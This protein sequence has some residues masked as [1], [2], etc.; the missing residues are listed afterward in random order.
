MDLN[1]ETP[2]NHKQDDGHHWT[3]ELWANRQKNGN[4]E[5][6]FTLSMTVD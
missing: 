4:A 2:K 3:I 1:I 6:I 5:A